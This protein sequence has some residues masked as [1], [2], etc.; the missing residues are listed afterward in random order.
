[1]FP[2]LFATLYASSAVKALLGTTPLR[3]YPAGEAT[4]DTPVPYAVFQTITGTPENYLGSRS[5]IDSFIVQVDVYAAT[6]SSA[7]A[8][9]SAI[10]VALEPVSYI[11]SLR[12]PSKDPTTRNY[13]YSLD[14]DFWTE[15]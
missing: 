10:R 15:R 7:R 8:C 14:V 6:L 2:P 13:R 12:E 11:T 1:M 5:D 9:A 4:Q 3:V